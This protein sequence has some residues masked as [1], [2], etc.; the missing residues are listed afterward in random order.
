MPE[1]TL[2]ALQTYGSYF[3]P[4]SV[5]EDEGYLVHHRIGNLSPARGRSRASTTRPRLHSHGRHAD[6]GPRRAT[7]VQS[8]LSITLRV[9]GSL[10][11]HPL[12]IT[13]A[14]Q[15]TR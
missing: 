11:F 7:G 2:A 9:T 15:D 10:R 8:R 4:F 12:L 5:H 1:A 6:V 13:R 14:A 3:G